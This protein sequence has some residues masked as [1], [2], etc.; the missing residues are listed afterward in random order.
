[1]AKVYVVPGNHRQFTNYCKENF[2]DPHD[3]NKVICCCRPERLRGRMFEPGDTV[4]YTGTWYYNQH[5]NE[6]RQYLE[7]MEALR[8]G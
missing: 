1:M 8:R 2:Y 5:I 3:S 7:M 4:E 6:I